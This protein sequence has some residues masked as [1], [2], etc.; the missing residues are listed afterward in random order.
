M[1]RTAQDTESLKKSEAALIQLLRRDALRL[2]RH[3]N[4][5]IDR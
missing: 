4:I 1:N 3:G 2:W 5:R